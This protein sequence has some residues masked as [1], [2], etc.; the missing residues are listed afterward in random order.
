MPG[1]MTLPACFFIPQ[2]WPVAAA[3]LLF[4]VGAVLVALRGWRGAAIAGFLALAVSIVI[5]VMLWPAVYVGMYCKLLGMAAVGAAGVI[6][7]RASRAAA[8]AEGPR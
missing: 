6:G 3:H 4:W 5:A 8:S 7:H 1:L 2:L